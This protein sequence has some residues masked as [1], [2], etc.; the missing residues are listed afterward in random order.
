MH[1][2]YVPPP[3]P[4]QSPSLSLA[5]ALTLFHAKYLFIAVCFIRHHVIDK[6]IHLFLY[7]TCVWPRM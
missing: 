2:P 3:T 4:L 6:C 7:A 1:T 5:V